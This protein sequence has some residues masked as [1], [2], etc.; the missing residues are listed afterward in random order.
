ML[1]WSYYG[2]RAWGYLFGFGK[3]TIL[4]YNLIFCSFIVIG[5]SMDL[6]K[7]VDFADAMMF[8]MAVFNIAG[9]YIMAGI[10][11]RDLEDYWQRHQAG[12]FKRVR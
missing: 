4:L 11:R 1:S 5:A 7:V 12:H 6:A 8:A 2:S 3:K 9:L 10:I